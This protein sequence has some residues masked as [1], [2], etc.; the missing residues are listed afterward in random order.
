VFEVANVL[1]T[2]ALAHYGTA[3]LLAVANEDSK[4][5]HAECATELRIAA[6]VL[7]HVGDNIL[8]RWVEPPAK[9]P[10]EVER[11]IVKGLALFFLATAQRITIAK[12][13]ETGTKHAVLAR[14]YQGAVDMYISAGALGHSC[15]YLRF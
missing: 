5:S 7:N 9:K 4:P 13:S 2:K 1:V 8:P 15:V 14:L 11:H 12:A 3:K 6:G 10:V